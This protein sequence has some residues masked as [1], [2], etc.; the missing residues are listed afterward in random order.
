MTA[1]VTT[2]HRLKGDRWFTMWRTLAPS[3]CA[4][5]PALTRGRV[6]AHICLMRATRGQI[7]PLLFVLCLGGAARPSQHGED[8]CAPKGPLTAQRARIAIVA[9]KQRPAASC[10]DIIV[11]GAHDDATAFCGQLARLELSRTY[12]RQ[13]GLRPVLDQPCS[14]DVLP[15]L[16]PERVALLQWDDPGPLDLISGAVDDPCQAQ[17]V[18]RVEARRRNVSVYL[19]VE[20]CAAQLG[21]LLQ[22]HRASQAA[23]DR[24]AQRWLGETA[25][26]AAQERDQACAPDPDSDRCATARMLL[27]VVEGRVD[28]PLPG[29]EEP[30]ACIP[31]SALQLD[32]LLAAG[33]P[34]DPELLLRLVDTAVTA[35]RLLYRY[36]PRHQTLRFVRARLR[37]LARGAI[38]V[39]GAG[40]DR[41]DT[42]FKVARGI[43]QRLQ[44]LQE[45]DAE[46]AQRYLE[47]HVQRQELTR[48]RKAYQRWLDRIGGDTVAVHDPSSAAGPTQA[49]TYAQLLVERVRAEG[50]LHFLRERYTE[51]HPRVI[52]ASSTVTQLGETLESLSPPNAATCAAAHAALGRAVDEAGGLASEDFA[53][54]HAA[55]IDALL[56]ARGRL[57]EICASAAK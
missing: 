55:I 18:E 39:P 56:L 6:L 43:E 44:R 19:K 14:S 15:A 48:E 50:S 17:R 11:S 25:A 33:L 40:A 2:R 36:G 51:R 13:S 52:A 35:E 21:R 42:H 29:V 45:A 20:A 16:D 53:S 1:I 31:A 32:E 3:G 10:T 26:R 4:L 37:R 30:A 38:E 27:E 54:E 47:R 12:P 9:A 22:A 24:A 5:T 49:E 34:A 46:L 8:V 28:A 57:D 41:H 7:L 23:A